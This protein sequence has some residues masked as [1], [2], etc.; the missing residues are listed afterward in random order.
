VELR[1]HRRHLAEMGRNARRVGMEKYD[2]YILAME[3]LDIIEKVKL[4]L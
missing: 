2:R 3:A 1:S 4:S